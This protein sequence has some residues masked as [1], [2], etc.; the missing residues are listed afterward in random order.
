VPPE[1]WAYQWIEALYD[2]GITSGCSEDPLM[3][4]PEDPVS[5]GQMAVF[6]ER[7]MRGAE[8]TPPTATGSVFVDVSA[9]YWAADWIEQLYADGITS[10]CTTDP[11]GYCPEDPVSRAQMAVFLERAMHWPAAFTPPA[12]TG[13]IFDDVPGSYWAVDWIEK[14]YADGI[15]EGCSLDPLLYCPEDSVTR[16]QMAVF[17]VR[18]FELPMP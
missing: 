18:T 1:H 11:L 16:A 14:L 4:C 3:Y 13:E 6:L 8:Y 7:G 15:T 2:S 5:R 12:G 10:G 17:L 9:D